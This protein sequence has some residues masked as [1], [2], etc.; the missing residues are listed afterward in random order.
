MVLNRPTRTTYNVFV[1]DL[2]RKAKKS[3][4]LIDNYVDDSVLVQ[5]AKRRKG[6][7]AVILTRNLGKKWFAFSKMDKSGLKL[8]ERVEIL[9]GSTYV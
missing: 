2:L 9:L 6:V 1:N 5:L 4:I 3:I 7:D 8:M